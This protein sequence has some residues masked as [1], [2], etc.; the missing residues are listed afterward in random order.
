M[1]DQELKDLVASLA[2]D[3]KENKWR[4]NMLNDRIGGLRNSIGEIVE[5]VLLPGLKEKMNDLSHNFYI[6]SP[7]REFSLPGGN[8]LTEVDLFLENCDEVMVVE[9]KTW[10]RIDD[11]ERLIIRMNK[12]RDNQKYTGVSGKK[13][14][15]AAAGIHIEDEVRSEILNKGIYL[16]KIDE[17]DDDRVKVTEPAGGAGGAVKAW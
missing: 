6:S 16:V 2:E 10:F 9:A 17:E 1:T 5:V 15:G 13:I 3:Q 11:V 7:R 4:M 14:Y 8:R 12:L